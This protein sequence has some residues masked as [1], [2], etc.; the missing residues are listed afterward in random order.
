MFTG[1]WNL[2]KLFI[3]A[4][5]THLPIKIMNKNK[6][7][8][9]SAQPGEELSGIKRLARTVLDSWIVIISREGQARSQKCSFWNTLHPSFHWGKTNPDVPSPFLLLIIIDHIWRL[10]SKLQFW[11]IYKNLTKEGHKTGEDISQYVFYNVIQQTYSVWHTTNVCFAFTAAREGQLGW[12]LEIVARPQWG[13]VHLFLSLPPVSGITATKTQRPGL[14]LQSNP[15]GNGIHL[16]RPTLS[17][18]IRL[19]HS[20][21]QTDP[22]PHKGSLEN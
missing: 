1:K 9:K 8:N 17:L 18:L 3:I 12:G 5:I 4:I 21:E 10:Y 13:G 2:I 15:W 20:S 14:L 16:P 7:Q 22:W 11:N 19:R 6:R